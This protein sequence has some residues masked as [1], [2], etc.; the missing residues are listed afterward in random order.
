MGQVAALPSAGACQRNASQIANQNQA[1]LRIAIMGTSA[2]L[3]TNQDEN[4]AN[5]VNPPF[6]MGKPV[7]ELRFLHWADIALWI[8]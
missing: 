6:S 1:A 7:G 8:G 5:L 3:H 4:R 2:G